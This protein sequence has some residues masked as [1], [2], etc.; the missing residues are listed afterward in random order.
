MYTLLLKLMKLW[1]LEDDF[2]QSLF[3]WFIINNINV[4]HLADEEEHSLATV[5]CDIWMKAVHFLKHYSQTYLLC[6][7]E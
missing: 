3:C 1:I 7:V 6:K 4:T 5:Y 2:Q